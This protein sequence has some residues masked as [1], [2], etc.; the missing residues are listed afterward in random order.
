MILEPKEIRILPIGGFNEVGGNMVC[1]ETTQDLIVIDCG[2]MFPAPNA[3]GC[4]KLAVDLSYLRQNRD[5]LRGFFITHGHEDHVGAL[6]FAINDFD[7]PIYG[8]D[9]TLDLIREKFDHH[10][11]TFTQYRP[12]QPREQTIFK[13]LKVEAISI[14]HSIPECFAFAIHS[15]AGTLIHTGDFKL[16]EN[17]IDKRKTDIERLSQ[18]GEK[19][20]LALIS[21]S[22]NATRDGHT[23][24]EKEVHKNLT[25][26]ISQA[27]GRVFTT[28][29]AS[30][31]HRIQGLIEAAEANNRHVIPMGRSVH[32]FLELG[33]RNNQIFAR[34]DTIKPLRLLRKLPPE[35]VLV[36]LTGCQGEPK[37]ASWRLAYGQDRELNPNSG[38]TFIFSSRTIPGNEIP[39]SRMTDQLLKRGVN[40]INAHDQEIHTSGHAHKDELREILNYCKPQYFI[41]GH[42]TIKL[43][44]AHAQIAFNE[45]WNPKNVFI[46]ENGHPLRLNTDDAILE[47]SIPISF[48]PI[49]ADSNQIIQLE[50]RLTRTDMAKH[51]CVALTIFE[52]Q[53]ATLLE[54]VAISC[55]GVVNPQEAEGLEKSLMQ[56]LKT[57]SK[58]VDADSV[59]EAVPKLQTMVRSVIRRRYNKNPYVHISVVDSLPAN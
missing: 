27:P 52:T 56:Y 12:L 5:K 2:I 29:F 57:E 3:Y 26:V 32:R 42:G 7:V 16:D 55:I 35:Q 51:G 19:G 22:T 58:S 10:K 45:G 46:L 49:E 31:C 28:L 18:L 20:V 21:D 23:Q 24:P 17:P 30:H 14:T 38:D 4:D 44:R 25:K 48:T 40:V 6:P 13:S 1:Y 33:K 50:T 53:N 41:P 9:F 8:S 11:I 37:S 47:K 34:Q 59:E 39:I 36:L 43:I 54:L 15:D